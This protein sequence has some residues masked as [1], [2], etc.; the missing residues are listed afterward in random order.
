MELKRFRLINFRQFKDLE[1]E[2]SNDPTKPFTVILGG[3]TYGKTTLVK[4]FLWCLYGKNDFKDKVLLNNEVLNEMG[5]GQD[6]IKEVK[7]VLDFEHNNFSYRVT[8]KE[9]YIKLADRKV[10]VYS[11]TSTNL[12]KSGDSGNAITMSTSSQIKDEIDNNVLDQELSSYFFFDGETN[13]IESITK[14]GNLTSAVSNIMGL[15]KIEKLKEYYNPS[16]ASSVVRRLSNKLVSSNDIELA[17]LN[18]KQDT[19]QRVLE[20]KLKELSDLEKSIAELTDQILTKEAILDANKD[21]L[22]YQKEKKEITADIENGKNLKNDKMNKAIFSFNQY[23][24][25]LNNLFAYSFEKTGI[26]NLLSKSTF[27]VKNSVSHIDGEAIDQ[28]IER[29]Y[30]LCNTKIENGNDAY[31]HLV[32]SK[33]HIAPKNYGKQ[34]QDFIENEKINLNYVADNLEK[35][36]GLCCEVTDLIAEI[37]NNTARLTNLIQKLDG[38]VN[39]I[40]TEKE[41]I[42]IKSQKLFQQ[43]QLDY[44][45][46]TTIPTLE[47]TINNV[48]QRIQ[49]IS[50]KCSENDFYHEC[51]RYAT[52][53]HKLASE[54]I[55]KEKTKIKANLQDTVGK[56]FT[57]MYHGNRKII[58]NDD[59]TVRTI[60]NSESDR[61][62]TSKGLD[63]VTNFSFVAGL[64]KLAKDKL[65]ESEDEFSDEKRDET[66]P[67]VMDAPF[68]NTDEDH[69]KNICMNLPKYCNQIV[70]IVMEKDYNTA[71][72][73]IS[74]KIGKK[75]RIIKN[76]ETFAHLKEEEL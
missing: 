8:T 39:A 68:S 33:N 5:V 60:V 46:N 55:V 7:A 44:L 72:S 73:D 54:R 37:D 71:S 53:I 21:I 30:C 45:N 14:K 27:T 34:I 16:S 1:V 22:T 47:N 52:H 43:N 61:L 19:N 70:I 42:E 36:Y 58:I 6:E 3:N 51:I 18:S 67:L 66:Y 50:L 65:N 20:E 28:L 2:F 41:I 9:S 23:N 29:G 76:S 4:A 75:Y 40:E 11:K 48:L 35:F 62:D 12:V 25:F 32:E 31:K 10:S 24:L 57:D 59:F 13:S 17:E 63:T 56:V 74:D 15:Q 26:E 49:S 64:M 69:I 38:K